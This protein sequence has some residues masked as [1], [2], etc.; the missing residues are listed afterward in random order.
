MTFEENLQQLQQLTEKLEKESLSLE[1]AI[2]V[3]QQ[4]MQ[5]SE[6]CQNALQEA[7]KQFSLITEEV[8]QG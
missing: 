8:Q 6:A 7:E 4:G 3:Y 2:A 5:L 1:E